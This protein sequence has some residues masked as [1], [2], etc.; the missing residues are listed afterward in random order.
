MANNNILFNA[1]LNGVGGAIFQRWLISATAA[2]YLRYRSA[3]VAFA[4]SVDRAIAPG[5]PTQQDADLLQSICAG[6]LGNRDIRSFVSADYDTV[7]ASILAMYTELQASLLSVTPQASPGQGL[8]KT[9]GSVELIAAVDT[10]II[11]LDPMTVA[12]RATFLLSWGGMISVNLAG[13]E[14]LS[15]SLEV[16]QPGSVTWDAC[17]G[18]SVQKT[19]ALTETQISVEISALGIASAA[20]AIQFRLAYTLVAADSSFIDTVSSMLAVQV[21]ATTLSP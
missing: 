15:I 9:T 16:M 6:V 12:L 8:Y 13:A 2:D 3:M 19:G 10:G 11:V 17:P 4:T 7:A 21:G 5:T 18:N 20:G 14:T 1:A